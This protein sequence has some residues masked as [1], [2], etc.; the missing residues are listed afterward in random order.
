MKA[1]FK[2]IFS[3]TAVLSVFTTSAQE[4]DWVINEVQDSIVNNPIG[5]YISTTKAIFDLDSNIVSVGTYYGI[6]DFDPGTGT[7]IRSSAHVDSPDD[8]DQCAFVK[9]MDRDGNLIWVQT[10]T[11][12][13]TAAFSN[14]TD[15][16]VNEFNNYFFIGA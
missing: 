2:L 3:I 14:M 9:K 4:L 13:G 6:V 8:F 10:Y 11:N 15:I 12:Q 7:E 1:L 16:V 5:N